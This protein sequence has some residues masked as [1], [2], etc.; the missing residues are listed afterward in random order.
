MSG[1]GRAAADLDVNI[2]SAQGGDPGEQ[3]A[4]PLTLAILLVAFGTLVAASLPFL[5]GLSTMQPAQGA[6]KKRAP[7]ARGPS[8]CG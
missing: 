1:D 8:F 7:R 4:L 3:R 5:T 2:W 6:K